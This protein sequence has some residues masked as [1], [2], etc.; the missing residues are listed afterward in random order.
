MPSLNRKNLCRNVYLLTERKNV[1]K[2]RV[3][4]TFDLVLQKENEFSDLWLIFTPFH[5]FAKKPQRLPV[6]F[7]NILVLLR[8]QVVCS[9]RQ[10]REL[11]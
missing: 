7:S 9:L 8:L 2:Q 1:Q 3:E 10:A 5:A 4:I 11:L 6:N